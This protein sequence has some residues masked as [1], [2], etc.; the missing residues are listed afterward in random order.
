MN[1]Q[2]FGMILLLSISTGLLADISV[3][4][5]SPVVPQ[6]LTDTLE[7]AVVTTVKMS[8]EP[9]IDLGDCTKDDQG[10]P[11]DCTEAFRKALDKMMKENSFKY[12][13]ATQSVVMVKKETEVDQECEQHVQENDGAATVVTQSVEAQDN[14][15]K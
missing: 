2:F 10:N 11:D 8:A 6:S 7:S 5:M 13:A 1:K 12:V 15:A 9:E 4:Q 3:N 14:S